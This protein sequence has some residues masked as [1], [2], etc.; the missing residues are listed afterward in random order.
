MSDAWCLYAE[1][2]GTIISSV[3]YLIGSHAIQVGTKDFNECNKPKN[4]YKQFS[5]WGAMHSLAN[6]PLA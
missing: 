6:T 5:F 4:L 3:F 2:V 1:L